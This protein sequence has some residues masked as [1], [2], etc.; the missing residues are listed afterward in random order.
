MILI[1]LS[2]HAITRMM[3]RTLIPPFSN[4][5]TLMND[6]LYSITAFEGSMVREEFQVIIRIIEY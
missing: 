6:T 3:N 4:L 2:A 1:A 5:E